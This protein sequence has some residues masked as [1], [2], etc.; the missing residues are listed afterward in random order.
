M[1][2]HEEHPI[3]SK[4]SSIRRRGH[5]WSNSRDTSGTG[6]KIQTRLLQYPEERDG[7]KLPL[8]YVNQLGREEKPDQ[9]TQSQHSSDINPTPEQGDTL[10]QSISLQEEDGEC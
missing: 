5:D 3:G 1:T 8:Q 2:T 10:G 9:T 7:F 6:E 4:S